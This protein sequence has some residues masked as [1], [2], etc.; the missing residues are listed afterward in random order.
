MDQATLD[1][2][3]KLYL[4]AN[5]AYNDGGKAIMTDAQFDKLEKEIARADPNWD[6]LR[7]TGSKVNK[8]VSVALLEPMPSLNKC[9]PETID[10]WLA[11]QKAKRLL[12][13]H[14]LDGSSLQGHYKNGRCVFLATRGDGQTG[15]DISF[16][17][18]HLKHTLPVIADKGD[19]V[20]RFEALI[21]T[22]KFKKWERAAKS[23]DKKDKDKF[24][25][26]RNM[27]NGLLNR[28][29]AHPALRD[30]DILVLGVYGKPMW[31][32]LKWAYDQCLKVAPYDFVTPETDFT[33]RLLK[34]RNSSIYDIDGLVLVAPERV[35]GYDSY[36][37]PKWTTAFKVNDDDDAVEAVVEEVVWQV[38]RTNRVVPKIQIKPV[39]I[40]GVEVT[41]A[42]AH[43]AQWMTERGIG[44][45]AVV[46]LVRSG[47]VIPKII[48][49][50]KKA[51]KPAVPDVEYKVEGVHFV[52]TERH[53]EADVREIHHFMTVLGIEHLASKSIAKLYDAKF[54]TVLDHL[55]AYGRR[56]RGYAEAGIGK[57][58]TAKIYGEFERVLHDKGVTLLKLMN[59]SNC[60][61]SFGE[62]KLAM[63]EQHFL[64]RGETDP[65]KAFVK[66]APKNLMDERNWYAVKSIKG[67][68]EASARQFFEGV[69]RFKEW[70][71]P[72]LKTKLIKINMPEVARKKK[73][74]KG[75]LSGEFVSFTSYR[76]T[77]HEAAVEARGGEVIKYG[78]KTTILLYKKGG[79]VS[80]KIE[81]ARAKG[82]KVCTFE[83]L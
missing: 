63:I 34:A 38:S 71:L 73:V 41:F 56:M 20:L 55:V 54:F 82:I 75:D 46:K 65:L 24:D 74:V 66:M 76:D 36:D 57:A 58:M 81:A 18:P 67:M 43:N 11:K 33:K 64:K 69:V 28:R 40:K 10:K 80:G 22:E 77:D 72:I 15:K 45:G 8:K 25:N 42:T 27:V 70:F 78:S 9:Y 3:K 2:K 7:K 61:E 60:F 49:V 52:A 29:D 32:G 68:G 16:L 51:K 31:E 13:L 79:K 4:K 14:K 12:M 35:F 6:Q 39:R 50:V 17:I 26:P 23:G 44:K 1:A 5:K 21:Q 59:A 53:K 37:K 48:D 19:I 62:R 30:V 83:E 47:D